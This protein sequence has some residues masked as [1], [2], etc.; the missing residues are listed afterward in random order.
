MNM[1]SRITGAFWRGLVCAALLLGLAAVG[2]GCA[3]AAPTARVPSQLA[4]VAGCDASRVTI[5]AVHS[6]REASGAWRVVGVITNGSTKAVGKVVTGV[7]TLTRAGQPADQGEDVS[8]YPLDLQPGAQAPFTAWID[9]EIPGLD[10]FKVEV[11]E[12]VLA[13][14]AERG[15]VDIHGGRLVVDGAGVAQVTAELFNPGSRPLLVNGLMAAV[16]DQAGVLV[17]ADYV[18]VATRYLEPGESGPVRASLDLP[19]GGAQQVKTYKFFMDALVNSPNPSSLDITRDVQVISH[20]TD[21]SGHFHLLGQ[22]TNPG[23][24][25]LMAGLQA[26]VYTDATRKFVADAANLNTWIPLQPG[27]TLPFDLTGWGALNNTP[28]L[29]DELAKQNAVIS[30]RIEPFLTWA[31][32]AREEKLAMVDGSVSIKDQQLVFTGKVRN[33]LAVSINNG[34][35]IVVLRQK[36]GGKILATGSAP[37]AI[38]DS[39]APGQVLDYFLSVSLPVNVEPAS[40]ETELTALGQ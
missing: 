19:H 8:A 5:N 3:T 20:Y 35:V 30:L 10:H 40:L 37:L 24:K 4:A 13:D 38:T 29:W 9:R 11:D 27:E 33:D 23:S 36:P 21:K 15:S 2:V 25:G 6:F 22:I 39:A 12:C 14:P 31:V 18:N 26:T 32:E 16:Y 17:T 1:N 7:E 34:V 28:G